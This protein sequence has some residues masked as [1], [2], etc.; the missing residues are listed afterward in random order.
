MLKTALSID[1]YSVVEANNGAEALGLFR[2]GGFDLVMLDLE[3]PFL[4]GDELARG[5]KKLAPR[6]P[7]LMVTGHDTRP[8]LQNPV[9]A[10]LRKPVVLTQLREV[11]ASLLA[12]TETRVAAVEV[13]AK[14][15]RGVCGPEP[16]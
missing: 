8:S 14:A 5:I 4:K 15:D 3:M 1:A 13:R 12:G 11:M 2:N 6:Q 16:E 10:L 9:D 7:I